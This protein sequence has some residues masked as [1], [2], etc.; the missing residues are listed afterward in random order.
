M[1]GPELASVIISVVAVVF[2]TGTAIYSTY[3]TAKTAR[4]TRVQT[5]KAESY[6]EVL[7]L[8]QLHAQQAETQSANMRIAANEPVLDF[9]RK[10]PQPEG[11]SAD[12]RAVIAAYL[13]AF[14]S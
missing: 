10:I 8:V 3:R 1:D 9:D 4:E 11:P 5:R 12:S 13:A 6:L 7:R 2:A 14:G